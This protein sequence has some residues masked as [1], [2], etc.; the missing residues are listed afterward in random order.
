[1]TPIERAKM[2][3]LVT[4]PEFERGY[5]RGRKIRSWVHENKTGLT[6]GAIALAATAI[7]IYRQRHT[8]PH[9]SVSGVWTELAKKQGMEIGAD[10]SIK[11]AQQY[12]NIINAKKSPN[13]GGAGLV[14]DGILGT[15]TGNAIRAFQA[16]N[17]LEQTGVIDDETGNA[18]L[19][20]VAAVSKSPIARKMA[21][22]TPKTF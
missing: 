12:L 4:S 3:R 18:L 14:E 10:L 22:V 9:F 17:G 6:L 19:Y 11:E 7:W 15:N 21:T 13:Q 5:D 1:M 16:G 2:L 8:S 20:F